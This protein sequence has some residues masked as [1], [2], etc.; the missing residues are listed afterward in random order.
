MTSP[1]ESVGHEI[2]AVHMQPEPQFWLLTCNKASP[3]ELLDYIRADWC[4]REYAGGVGSLASGFSWTASSTQDP[5]LPER[6]FEVRPL[7]T[8]EAL[9]WIRAHRPVTA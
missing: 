9:A 3:G 6:D 8:D 1:R 2:D 4:L 7:T 5:R